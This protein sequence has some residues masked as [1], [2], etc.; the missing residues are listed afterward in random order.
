MNTNTQEALA[1][2]ASISSMIE[3]FAKSM[4]AQKINIYPITMIGGCNTACHETYEESTYQDDN[5][6][7]ILEEIEL[8]EVEGEN[9]GC[10]TGCMDCLGLSWADF[11]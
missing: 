1:K 10:C 3:D 4:A 11:V 5:H 6:D 8:D 9:L 7:D 2:V